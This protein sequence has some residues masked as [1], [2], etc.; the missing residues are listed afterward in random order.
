ALKYFLGVL[1]AFT[2]D[3]VAAIVADVFE[4]CFYELADFFFGVGYFGGVIIVFEVYKLCVDEGVLYAS[5]CQDLHDAK[6]LF[7]SVISLA[8]YLQ[9]GCHFEACKSSSPKGLTSTKSQ[10]N[11]SKS[12]EIHKNKTLKNSRSKRKT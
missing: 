9:T 7:S 6:D 10:Q 8:I 3:F 12:N 4:A 5:I 11:R 1:P 2:E